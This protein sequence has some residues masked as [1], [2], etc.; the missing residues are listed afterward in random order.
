MQTRHTLLE[1]VRDRA[2]ENS[3]SEFDKIYRPYI[4]KVIRR[5]NFTHEEAEDLSQNILVTL[6]EK[7]PEFKHNFRT[8]AF[9]TWLCTIIRNR[10]INIITKN[11]RRA[12]KLTI[13]NEDALTPYI[14]TSQNDLEL[15][16]KEEWAAHI[17]A[18]AWKKIEVEFDENIRKAF[19]MSLDNVPYE[20][21]SAQLGLKVNSIYVYK[22]KIKKRLTEIVRLL[23]E[24]YV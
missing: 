14:Q 13:E 4:Y 19:K 16:A 10:A 9:R 1:R 7:I 17:T 23:K 24:Q 6:W 5:M 12:S 18:L 15:I 2:D 8:G 22:N 3:W 11:K 21:I 20:D